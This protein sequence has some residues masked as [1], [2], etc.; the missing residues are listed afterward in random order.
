MPAI[1]TGMTEPAWYAFTMRFKSAKAPNGLTREQFVDELL[2]RGL[3]DVDIPRST[4]LLHRE[5]LYIKPQELFPYLYT[6]EHFKESTTQTFDTAQAFYDEAIKFPVYATSEGQKATDCY[7]EIILDV[8]AAC[9]T[10]DLSSGT[11][12][13]GRLDV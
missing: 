12:V 8:A 5:P 10:Q 11:E 13:C 6:E 9:L 7:I 4:G 1:D 3:L 2:A